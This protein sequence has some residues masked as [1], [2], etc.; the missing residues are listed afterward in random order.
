[1]PKEKQLPPHNRRRQQTAEQSLR[2]NGMRYLTGGPET[3]APAEIKR[4]PEQYL[5]RKA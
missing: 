4:A 2:W 1:M 3:V 5:G